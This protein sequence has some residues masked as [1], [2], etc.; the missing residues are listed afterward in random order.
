MKPSNLET[1]VETHVRDE[2]FFT[3]ADRRS[4]PRR[5]KSQSVAV[6]P[7]LLDGGPGELQWADASTDDVSATGLSITIE[8]RD[9]LRSHAAVIGAAS[10]TG[11]RAFATMQIV[12]QQANGTSLRISGRWVIGS[13][14][15]V[16]VP[17][18]LRPRVDPRTLS[19]VY[20]WA[21]ETLDDWT[22]LGVLRPYVVDR[23]LLCDRCGSIPSWRNGCHV[24]GSGRIH[25]DR[26][27]H[28]FAC[29]HVGRAGDFETASGL[30]C[31]KCRA[32]SLIVGSDYEY[33]EGPVECY[34][35]GAKGGQ[36]TMAAMCHRCH[37]RFSIDEAEERVL[38]AYH[39]ERLDPLAFYG[40]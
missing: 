8:G 33:I 25:R 7:I 39:V 12:S 34:D 26:L 16:L 27:V 35:C 36:P 40:S 1:T 21:S 10:P 9:Q 19:F 11:G 20:G 30:Q 24:C 15:D 32:A 29:A 18:K 4:M 37:H 3:E 22:K 23:V 38:Y 28:H 17:D 5:S 31:P 6:I 14:E 2:R 13:A